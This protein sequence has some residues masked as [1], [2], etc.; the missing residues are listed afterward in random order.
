LQN[1]DVIFS[2]NAPDGEATVFL[3]PNTLSSDGT[4]AMTSHS[5]TEKGMYYFLCSAS[6][7]AAFLDEV[8]DCSAR[9][10]KCMLS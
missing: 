3:D 1:Q 4:V 7:Q 5:F 6:A 10:L 9:G 8:R 2:S